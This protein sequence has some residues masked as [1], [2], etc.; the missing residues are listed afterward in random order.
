[1]TNDEKKEMLLKLVDALCS[2]DFSK[3]ENEI[4]VWSQKLNEIYADGY[5]HSYSDLFYKLQEILLRDSED[6]DILGENLNVLEHH[7]TKILEQSADDSGLQRTVESYRKFADHIRLEIG[8]YNFIKIR[9]KQAEEQSKIPS[10]PEAE[11]IRKQVDDLSKAVDKMRPISTQALKVTENLDSILESNKISSITALT[12]FSAVVLAFSGGF[13]FEAGVL[14]GMTSATAYRLVFTVSLTGFILFNT[15]FMLLYLV[16]KMAGKSISTKCKYNIAEKQ[17]GMNCNRRCGNGYCAQAFNDI[18]IMCRIFHKYWYVAVVDLILLWVMYA[19]FIL[20]FYKPK[21]LNIAI[22]GVIFLPATLVILCYIVR[23]TNR[24]LQKRANILL[25][26]TDLISYILNSEKQSYPF[27]DAIRIMSSVIETIAGVKKKG[28][29][30]EYY[31]YIKE[32]NPQKD[33]KKI[34]KAT[35]DFVEKL[36]IDGEKMATIVP[37]DKNR[38]NKKEWKILKEKLKFHLTKMYQVEG[39]R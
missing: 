14:Q 6:S 39:Q 3:N 27:F 36:I 35:D 23:A 12:V 17:D 22:I 2:A 7:I 37:R 11:Q 29:D 13:T 1:M 38:Q 26:K 25:Y 15:I 16:G 19:D 34:L 30:E 8:R 32:Y 9:F 31:N 4:E 10:L 28:I 24:Y 20:W 5:R 33:Y 21:E 18:S